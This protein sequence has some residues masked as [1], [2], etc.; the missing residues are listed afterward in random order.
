MAYANKNLKSP[1]TPNALAR[2]PS[3]LSPVRGRS[4]RLGKVWESM[5]RNTSISNAE[6][7]LAAKDEEIADL[8]RQLDGER[9]RWAT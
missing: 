5:G 3:S 6:L 8:K 7:Q 4:G 9:R 2:S 1:K